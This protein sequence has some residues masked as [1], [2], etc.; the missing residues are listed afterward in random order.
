M[1]LNRPFRIE[2]EISSL[3]NAKCSGCQRTMLD[4]KGEYYFK[5]NIS[6]EQMYDWFDDVDLKD[7]RIKLCGVLGDPIINPDC[8]DICSY[9][10]L[11]K[12]VKSIEVSTNG[13]TRS[14][15]FWL[16]LAE[17][18][19][20]TNKDI[21]QSK[22]SKHFS[23]INNLRIELNNLACNDDLVYLKGSRS[24]QLERIYQL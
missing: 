10:L 6:I 24:M 22:Y 19:K 13:G 3:C 1:N 9:L 12:H 15:N 7:A 20:H 18:S 17:L 14:K 23:N 5:G 11:E 16:E 2:F 21:N 8:V 4:K